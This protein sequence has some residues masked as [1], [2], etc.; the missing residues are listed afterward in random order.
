MVKTQLS[1][2]G[3]APLKM[4]EMVYC[5]A[6]QQRGD[7]EAVPGCC[8]QLKLRTVVSARKRIYRCG[9]QNLIS[10]GAK[11][12]RRGGKRRRNGVAEVE[13]NQ[14]GWTEDTAGGPPEDES[15][16]TDA[17]FSP[18]AAGM[19]RTMSFEST[20]TLQEGPRSLRRIQPPLS[21]IYR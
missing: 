18:S 20:P 17:H 16:Q 14:P 15:A 9:I 6:A 5:E 8:K 12:R 4:E 10:A 19:G 11:N 3:E 13:K 21:A 7:L 1:D 2:G